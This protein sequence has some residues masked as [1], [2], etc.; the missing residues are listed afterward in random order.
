MHDYAMPRL[1]KTITDFNSIWK[2]MVS[3]RELGF[4]R[5]IISQR[6]SSRAPTL[7]FNSDYL[8]QVQARVQP[9][10]P[11]MLKRA[12]DVRAKSHNEWRRRTQQFNTHKHAEKACRLHIKQQHQNQHRPN[13]SGRVCDLS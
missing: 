10:T 13:R 6:H 2:R 9:T 11:I 12:R 4:T 8:A 3:G 1:K 7:K 5:R